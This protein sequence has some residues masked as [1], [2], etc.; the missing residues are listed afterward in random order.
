MKGLL[1][2]GLI[3]IALV[4]LLGCSPDL[5]NELNHIQGHYSFHHTNQFNDACRYEV[6]VSG[7]NLSVDLF[8][9]E[10]GQK[11]WTGEIISVE[12]DHGWLK[13]KTRMN[14]SDND[15]RDVEVWYDS[16]SE[17][18]RIHLELNDLSL[19]TDD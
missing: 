15:R 17:R 8:H 9:P 16:S 11:T 13:F 2:C 19:N 12:R 10:F 1:N 5:N 3:C 7:T 14:E 18:K 6:H 4:F